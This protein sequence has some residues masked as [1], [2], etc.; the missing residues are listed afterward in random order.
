[1]K[2]IFLPFL[3]LFLTISSIAQTRKTVSFDEGWKFFKGDAP[4]AEASSFDD[5]A[6]RSLNVPH[7]WSIEG[8]YDR[9]NTTGRGGGYLPAGIGWYRKTFSL[10][11]A[12]AGRKTFIQFDGVMA[13]SDVWINGKHLGGRPNGYVAFEYDLTPHLKFGSENT[14]AVRAD[15]SV[16]PASRWYAG[17]GIYRHV[18]LVTTSPVH[19]KQFGHFITTKDVSAKGATVNVQTEIAAPA[20]SNDLTVQTTIIA[21]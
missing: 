18:R 4:G 3:F 17:A 8:P 2:R 6:W 20:G 21:P 15:N 19:V 16:Q 9:A 12:Y 14:I 13:N 5:K 1:M 11:S 7:D 10:T